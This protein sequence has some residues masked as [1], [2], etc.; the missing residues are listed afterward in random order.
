MAWTQAA[1]D[2]AAMARKM[3][4]G[5][6]SFVK[7]YAKMM[8]KAGTTAFNAP[9]AASRTLIAKAIKAHRSGSLGKKLT[10]SKRNAIQTMVHAA[11]VSTMERN[12]FRLAK[13]K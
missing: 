11:A 5:A 12:S 8:Q 6:K 10:P 13:R 3:H 1:R 7:P 2:A 9:S 4:V